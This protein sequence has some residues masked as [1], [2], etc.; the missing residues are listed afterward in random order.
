M[1]A[2]EIV[3]NLQA[4]KESPSIGVSD[5]VRMILLEA[6]L[7]Q[8]KLTDATNA[9]IKAVAGFFGYE[10]VDEDC[11]ELRTTQAAW[12]REEPLIDAVN[13]FLDAFER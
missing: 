11:D 2:H 9:D 1:N 3:N 5:S 8:V 12:N 4:L 7:G 6:A 13:D 10:F